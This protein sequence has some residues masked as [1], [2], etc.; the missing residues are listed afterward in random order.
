[1]WDLCREQAE[2]GLARFVI[3]NRLL[4][5]EIQGGKRVDIVTVGDFGVIRMIL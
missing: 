2:E 5:H 3:T 1:M 4:A